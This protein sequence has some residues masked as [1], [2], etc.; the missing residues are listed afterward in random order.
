MQ[1]FQ[2]VRTL[3][4]LAQVCCLLL[5]VG[6]LLIEAVLQ[7]VGDDFVQ[8]HRQNPVLVL[9]LEQLSLHVCAVGKPLQA[10]A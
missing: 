5:E 7:W 4:R 3:E 2:F 8:L 1:F 6:D 9:N 10:A